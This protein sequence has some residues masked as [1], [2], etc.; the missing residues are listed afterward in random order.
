MERDKR[1]INIDGE[2]K[3]EDRGEE[4]NGVWALKNNEAMPVPTEEVKRKT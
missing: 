3:E 2:K 1:K 4:Q